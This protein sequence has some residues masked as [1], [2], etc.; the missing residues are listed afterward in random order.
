MG[1]HH[2]EHIASLVENLYVGIEENCEKT[3]KSQRFHA[4][5]GLAECRHALTYLSDDDKQK[6]LRKLRAAERKVTKH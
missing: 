3:T 2:K 5:E 4:L 6:I 1:Y